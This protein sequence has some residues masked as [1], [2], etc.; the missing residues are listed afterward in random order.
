MFKRMNDIHNDCLRQNKLVLDKEYRYDFI[1]I[2]TTGVMML[3]SIAIAPYFFVFT[4][5]LNSPFTVYINIMPNDCIDPLQITKHQNCYF[6]YINLRDLK[7]ENLKIH[8]NLM[9]KKKSNEVFVSIFD[10]IYY[11][12]RDDEEVKVEKVNYL[13]FAIA[14][15]FNSEILLPPNFSLQLNIIEKLFYYYEIEDLD[16]HEK[17]YDEIVKLNKELEHITTQKRLVPN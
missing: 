10:Q 1:N 14:R 16:E 15:Y 7:N 12:L 17:T 11:H 9:I 4:T 6:K 3:D 5:K 13:L 8:D 2:E